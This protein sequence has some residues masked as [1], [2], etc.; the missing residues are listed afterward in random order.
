LVIFAGHDEDFKVNISYRDRLC[1][2]F[3]AIGTSLVIL[4]NVLTQLN[5]C[6]HHFGPDMDRRINILNIVW[7]IIYAAYATALIAYVAHGVI[8]WVLGHESPY[9]TYEHQY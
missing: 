3:L 2:D 1:I 4:F 7:S 6:V 5:F 9:I 8:A